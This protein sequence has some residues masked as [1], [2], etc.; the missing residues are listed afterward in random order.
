MQVTVN[1]F[2]MTTGMRKATLLIFMY[3]IKFSS[4]RLQ[5]F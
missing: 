4:A 5:G 1:G 2:A 3:R